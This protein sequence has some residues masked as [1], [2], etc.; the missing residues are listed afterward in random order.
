MLRFQQELFLHVS[1]WFNAYFEV[2]GIRT[3][4]FSFL[5]SGASLSH[6]FNQF[7]DGANHPFHDSK[8]SKNKYL[9]Y[10]IS[11]YTLLRMHMKKNISNIQLIVYPINCSNGSM[12]LKH[13]TIISIYPD[14]YIHDVLVEKHNPQDIS[15]TVIC[16]EISP[17]K[18]DSRPFKFYTVILVVLHTFTN[19]WGYASMRTVFF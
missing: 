8:A 4:N 5:L 18:N 10:P 17:L 11:I 14:G 3:S 6:S 2:Q 7:L 12:S 13:V 9:L 15:N 19:C 16:P 1:M